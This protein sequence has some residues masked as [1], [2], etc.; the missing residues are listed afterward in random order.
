ML[1]FCIIS[2]YFENIGTQFERRNASAQFHVYVFGAGVHF[3]KRH[4]SQRWNHYYL[5]H[6]P[7]PNL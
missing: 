5:L 2:A 6:N 7:T 4:T 3:A 1:N